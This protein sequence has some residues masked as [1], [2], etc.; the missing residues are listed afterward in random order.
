MFQVV[1]DDTL[2]F[3]AKCLKLPWAARTAEG[4]HEQEEEEDQLSLSSDLFSSIGHWGLPVKQTKLTAVT[5]QRD[6]ALTRILSNLVGEA[7]VGQTT[8]AQESPV[9]GASTPYSFMHY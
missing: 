1:E 4:D 6:R 9:A 8:E 3:L 2:S 5:E 7:I